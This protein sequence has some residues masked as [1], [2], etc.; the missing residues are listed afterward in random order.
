[1]IIGIT[2]GIGSGKSTIARRLEQKYGFTIYDTDSNAK[3]IIT[4]DKEVRQAVEHL[5]GK[6]VFDGNNYN[7]RLA[8]QRIF[9]D[10]DILLRMNSIVHPAVAQDI[11][12]HGEDKL[13][14]ES[15]LLY[16]VPAIADICDMTVAVIAPDD[17]RL[18]RAMKRDGVSSEEISARINK[19]MSSDEMAQRADIVVNND[20]NN[21]ID[22][23]A[24]HI[25][26]EVNKRLTI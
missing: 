3:R 6:D 1:M 16:D 10:K 13:L 26:T 23:L 24:K 2:G 14:I 11:L 5:L 8:A 18:K 22:E 7:T 17:I 20:G 15:A 4:Q 9:A 12:R 25:I 19:Q 21:T